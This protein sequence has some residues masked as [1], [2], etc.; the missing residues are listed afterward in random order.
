M[1]STPRILQ[2]PYARPRYLPS[3][4]ALT[5]AGSDNIVHANNKKN[6]K[7]HAN[8]FKKIQAALK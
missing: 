8:P 2:N 6:S 1:E 4:I 7:H 3:T 5:P